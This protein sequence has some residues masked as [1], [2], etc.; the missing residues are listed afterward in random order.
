MFGIF[1]SKSEKI[2]AAMV[3]VAFCNSVGPEE[4]AAVRESGIDERIYLVEANALQAYIVLHGFLVWSA[5][6]P[7]QQ[8]EMEVV[9]RFYFLVNDRCRKTSPIPDQYYN[10]LLMRIGEYRQARKADDMA[11]E[12]AIAMEFTRVFVANLTLPNGEIPFE[13]M[14]SVMSRYEFII[15]KLRLRLDEF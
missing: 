3:D 7:E 8:I 15:K 2:A 4:I 10:L 6:T 9:E 14:N 1:K 5:S 11:P 13:F 12:G